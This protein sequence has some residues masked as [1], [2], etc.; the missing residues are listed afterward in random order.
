MIEPTSASLRWDVG[1]GR[2]RRRSGLDAVIVATNETAMLVYVELAEDP[3]VGSR[4]VVELAGRLATVEV[5]HVA[6]TGDPGSLVGVELVEPDGPMRA[7]LAAL[8]SGADGEGAHDRW[9]WQSPSGPA[10]T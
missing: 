8:A 4:V 5:R 9:W 1:R 7:H 3:V 6:P 10:A 2:L